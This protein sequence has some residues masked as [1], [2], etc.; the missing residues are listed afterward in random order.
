MWRNTRQGLGSGPGLESGLGPAPEPGL[1]TW[2]PDL[3]SASG[4]GLRTLPLDLA[5]TVDPASGPWLWTWPLDLAFGPGL[6]TW[7]LDPGPDLG[8]DLGP[9]P[10]PGLGPDLPPRRSGS[11]AP[12]DRQGQRAVRG[13][14]RSPQLTA[15]HLAKPSTMPGP[16]T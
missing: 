14:H 7:P 13:D 10:D 16:Q 9:G 6:R 15:D 1:W 2:P 4:P 3:T 12:G 11:S 5:W 8:P